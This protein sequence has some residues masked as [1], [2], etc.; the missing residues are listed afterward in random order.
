M[1]APSVNMNIAV[2]KDLNEQL[3]TV[4]AGTD[5]FRTKVADL[6]KELQGLSSVVGSMPT[7]LAGL[8][9]QM[10]TAG[11]A[12]SPQKVTQAFAQQGMPQQPAPTVTAPVG[13]MTPTAQ[14]SAIA[15]T[16][17]PVTGSEMQFGLT[18]VLADFV[19]ESRSIR[20]A[21]ENLGKQF[22]ADAKGATGT[23][24]PPVNKPDEPPFTP[25]TSAPATISGRLGVFTD[26]EKELARRAFQ[27]TGIRPASIE[28][29]LSAERFTQP[30]TQSRITDSIDRLSERLG[31]VDGTLAKTLVDE[32]NK[33]KTT[34][35]GNSDV[36]NNFNES[37]KRYNEAV[38]QQRPE[39]EISKAYS[40]LSKSVKQI[41]DSAEKY[42]EA[43]RL[44]EE[45]AGGAQQPEG[46]GKALRKG[47]G[48][49]VPYIAGVAAGAMDVTREGFSFYKEMEGQDIASQR[50]ILAGRGRLGQQQFQNYSEQFNM[51]NARNVMRWYGDV[52]APNTFEF[53]GPQGFQKAKDKAL[54]EQAREQELKETERKVQMGTGV[55]DLA[56]SALQLVGSRMLMSGAA[57]A[58]VGTVAPGLGNLI[59]G[60]GGALIG[61][62]MAFDAIKD[63][64]TNFN[65][66][67]SSLAASPA[68]EA[69][70]GRADTWYGRAAAGVF[71]DRDTKKMADRTRERFGLERANE[72]MER[73]REMQ[74]SEINR[75]PM[76]EQAIQ[77][78]LELKRMRYQA[79][80]SLGRFAGLPFAARPI[81]GLEEAQTAFDQSIQE[82]RKAGVAGARAGGMYVPET[83][84][85]RSPTATEN[86]MTDLYARAFPTTLGQQPYREKTQLDQFN[87]FA[88]PFAKQMGGV[89]PEE[90]DFLAYKFGKE[91]GGIPK[92]LQV[93]APAIMGDYTDAGAESPEM[94][95]RMQIQSWR[96]EFK[97]PAA[98]KRREEAARDVELMAGE[99]AR[100]DQQKANQEVFDRN[101]EN[102][103]KRDDK[104]NY[105]NLP[106]ANLGLGPQEVAQRAYSYQNMLGVG[107]MRRTEDVVASNDFMRLNK[108]SM[109]GLGT[110]EQINQNVG[111]LQAI[112]GQRTDQAQKD[113]ERIFS[114]GVEA[115]FNNSRLAQ[116]LVQTSTSLAENLNLRN[117]SGVTSS[118]LEGARVAGAGKIDERLLQDTAR[119]MQQ[120][121][122]M[123]GAKEGPMA[124]LRLGGILQG[125][126]LP[127]QGSGILFGMSSAQA[128]DTLQQVQE[129][130]GM[131]KAWK[132]AHSDDPKERQKIRDPNLRSM[133]FNA[134]SPDD[135]KTSLEGVKKTGTILAGGAWN[136][137]KKEGEKDFESTQEEVMKEVRE[138][139]SNKEK[140]R[141]AMNK[142]DKFNMTLRARF[143]DTYG[144][145]GADMAS[146]YVGQLLSDPSLT[147]S[148]RKAY[149]KQLKVDTG[150]E[151]KKQAAFQT[152]LTA[153]GTSLLQGTPTLKQYSQLMQSGDMTRTLSS[154]EVL[155][156]KQIS[157]LAK[158]P[159]SELTKE[160]KLAKAE[161]EE[162]L[163]KETVSSMM[164]QRQ[165]SMRDVSEPPKPIIMSGVEQSA[166]EKIGEA[167]ARAIQHG[168]RYGGAPVFDTKSPRK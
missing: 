119:G 97:D 61:G 78:A 96:N 45:V 159:E 112:T 7:G 109:A 15:A 147:D 107:Q 42:G 149:Q 136:L 154:G 148:Q 24:K 67:Q 74:E 34:F 83:E 92:E 62:Y 68:L 117:V 39:Q 95:A 166:A 164:A 85:L 84:S 129:L 145:Q 65:R 33:L 130:G 106:Y 110:F 28:D 37:L 46:F 52:L 160:Q 134:K 163:K 89:T 98:K 124:A 81:E 9:Q 87:E 114:K 76:M 58:A 18:K 17:A 43:I 21:V 75:F 3:Q 144:A 41:N 73:A 99:K 59:G 135:I 104:G 48:R 162:G 66:M 70:G 108:M 71:G 121:A 50:Q 53:A 167:V 115:G 165:M 4:T 146:A 1:A 11:G 44:G 168:D 69:E 55:G 153:F 51:Y 88:K 35:S 122:A 142:M 118:L 10:Q 22:A 86:F 123:T 47:F 2:F 49:A 126:T 157:Y 132:M 57:G 128:N 27:K 13:T 19:T 140:Q 23:A 30:A 29:T 20:T 111:A 120:M 72:A 38:S 8:A 80:P 36:V 138:A 16:A 25:P 6:V 161:I 101:M 133:L 91:G 12:F 131:E 100:G 102:M 14:A 152:S 150:E 125:G 5:I 94:Q 90:R 82:A 60:T 139:G 116:T 113:L 77:S 143:A 26:E 155:S 137:W 63:M 32:L 31:K 93:R 158:T 54:T 79:L 40:D 127:G 141:A 151:Q 103:M 105:V 156:G 56:L 64:I